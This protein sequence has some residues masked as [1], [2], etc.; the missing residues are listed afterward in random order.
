MDEDRPVERSIFAIR[1]LGD[2]DREA[3]SG[4]LD[5]L[6]YNLILGYGCGSEARSII[7]AAKTQSTMGN[8]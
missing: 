6:V 5:V 4:D 1:E 8:S 2:P 7:C 3:A